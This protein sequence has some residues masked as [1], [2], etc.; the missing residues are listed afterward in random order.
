MGEDDLEDNDL[1]GA[2]GVLI[3]VRSILEEDPDEEEMEI[4][5]TI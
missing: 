5:E 2:E 1:E 3:A 4:E